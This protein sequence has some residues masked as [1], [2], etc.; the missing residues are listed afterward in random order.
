MTCARS[1]R[2]SRTRAPAIGGSVDALLEFVK[3]TQG[4]QPLQPALDALYDLFG[5]D[6][7][8]LS[9]R[10]SN[11]PGMRTVLTVDRNTDHRRP[12]LD[13]P[14]ARHVL[15]RD[16][17]TLKAGVAVLH[18]EMDVTADATLDRWI[19]KRGV[20]DIAILCLGSKNGQRDMLEVHFTHDLPRGWI[21]EAGKI[22]RSLAEVFAGRRAGLV[23][24]H[25]L[26]KSDNRSQAGCSDEQ[27]LILSPENHIGLTRSEW[28]LC[29]LIANGLSREGAAREMEV[30]ENTIRTHL[31][32]VYAKTGCKN[33][34]DLARRLVR[35]EEQR[36]LQA[37]A[38]GHAA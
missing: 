19:T 2:E 34:H 30:T 32:N 7:L 9:R 5:A 13:T 4:Q 21:K 23:E 31:R 28:R 16:L 37:L 29:V 1:L 15:G 12:R 3:W 25:L 6:V 11:K 20:K 27:A 8:C 22:S 36:A 14:F 10:E 33:F 35:L 17:D 18:S 26:S 38:I 24:H